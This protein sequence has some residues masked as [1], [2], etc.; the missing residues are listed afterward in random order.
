MLSNYATRRVTI[1]KYLMIFW[2]QEADQDKHDAI[3]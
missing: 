2:V 1:P 3:L